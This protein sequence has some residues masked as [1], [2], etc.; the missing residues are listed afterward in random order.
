MPTDTRDLVDPA[1]FSRLESLELRARSI[2]KGLLHGLH[3]SHYV[4][5]SVEFSSHWE[6]VPGDDPR[7]VNWKVAGDSM[8]HLAQAV[9]TCAC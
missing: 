8:S 3:R 5:F 6:Y 4:G 1:F 9:N 2:V 7:H